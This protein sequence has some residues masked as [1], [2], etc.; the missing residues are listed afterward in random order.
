MRETRAVRQM[1]AMA[2]LLLIPAWTFGA[3]F[4]L[5]EHG[6]RGVALGGA[7][8]ATANDPTALY[9]NPAG[10]AFIDGTQVAAGAYFIALTSDFKGANPYPGVGYK[11]SQEKQLFTPPH[12]YAT[13]A[14]AGN[15]RWGI[16]LNT[17]FGLGTYW[18]NDFA[19]RYITKRVVLQVLNFNPTVSYKLSDSFAVAIG[20]DYYIT[21]VDL[22]RS[23]GAVNP[24]T[25]Q[26]A[27][28][29][30]VHMYARNQ[31]GLG[32]NIGVLG[33]LG[34]GFSAGVSYR[35]NV[36]VEMKGK[37]SFVQ[38][39][40]GNNEF[41]A[42]VSKQLPFEENPEAETGID[43]PDETRLSLAWESGAWR[44]EVDAVRMG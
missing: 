33:K 41:D 35:S 2:V 7:F 18:P 23:A 36:D 9:Y 21:K 15:L 38:I 29:A 8:G 39:R 16:G 44:A 26:V 42:I 11:S 14:I 3:G 4:A 19:G 20:A 17:P 30:N 27:E 5:F 6:A 40:T 10:L 1:A 32:W 28:I 12:V 43:F 37:A 22:T 25:Q 31:T 13:G 34:A 24:F